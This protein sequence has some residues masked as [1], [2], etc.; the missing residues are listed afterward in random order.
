MEKI[1]LKVFFPIFLFF[2]LFGFAEISHSASHYVRQGATGNGSDWTNAYSNLPD[3]LT[4]GDTYYISDGSYGGY[5]F[6]DANSGTSVITVKKAI[7]ADHGTDTGWNSGYGDGQAVF[8]DMQ[9][10]TGYYVIDGQRRNENDWQDVSGYGFR[11]TGGIYS[12]ALNPGPA[13]ADNLT[14][15][16]MDMGGSAIGNVYSEGNPD[17][18]IY[19]GGFGEY[20]NNW[21][22]S[23]CHIHNVGIAIQ[24]AGQD[25]MVVESNFIGP[26]WSKEAIR[27]QSRFSNS[28]IRHNVMWN[29]C[30]MDPIEGSSSGCTAEIALWAGDTSGYFSGNQIYGNII[31]KTTDESNSG[32]A[33]IVGG[34]GSNWSGV[35]ASNTLVYNNTIVGLKE[36]RSD[37][38]INGGTGNVV[39]NNLW[40]DISGD[41]RYWYVGANTTSN[42]VIMDTSIFVDYP[43]DLRLSGATESGFGLSA[44]Y[45][46]DMLNVTR[47]ADG[48]WDIGAYEYVSGAS[49]T[50]SPSPPAGVTVR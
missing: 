10:A 20:C 23:R 29:A 47:G 24:G 3:S 39:R 37:I 43:T 28:T 18:G 16:Y 38:L 45:N 1:K 9:F 50:T 32:G 44:P 5:T 6:D 8:S 7:A 42:N 22:I 49:D 48:T 31:Q 33:I 27:G 40:A 19:M 15:R 21:T 30:Q 46:T 14:V 41:S 35:P 12:S 4:R 13:C 34:D 11:N 36:W 17:S 26:S 25:G 2:G